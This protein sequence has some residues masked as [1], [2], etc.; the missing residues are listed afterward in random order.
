M[1]SKVIVLLFI[2]MMSNRPER[3]WIFNYTNYSS[4]NIFLV[5]ASGQS[6]PVH[7]GTTLHLLMSVAN[8]NQ[9]TLTIAPR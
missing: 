5:T 3:A 7:P 1:T 4:R 2:F 8:N 9:V 6:L